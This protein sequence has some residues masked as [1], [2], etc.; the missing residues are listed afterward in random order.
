MG[1]YR[2]KTINRLAPEGLALFGS[3]FEVGPDEVNPHGIVVRSSQ[4]DT[5]DYPE[6]LAVARAGAG[7]NNITVDK[8]TEHGICV[9][10]TPGANANAVAELLF[11]ML[12]I[13]M[14]HI[15]EGIELKG[16]LQGSGTGRQD[17]WRHWRGKNRCNGCKWRCAETYESGCF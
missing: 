5:G 14:R 9:F 17:P 7:V 11:T 1:F 15:H 13:Q 2:I 4:V 16:S 10:N 12:G 3:N 6:L 8:A